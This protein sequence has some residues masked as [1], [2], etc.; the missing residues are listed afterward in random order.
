MMKGLNQVK[1]QGT[2]LRV[3]HLKLPRAAANQEIELE[4]TEREIRRDKLRNIDAREAASG[5]TE[6]RKFERLEREINT[7]AFDNA[8]CER[9]RSDLE[10]L[11]AYET[12]LELEEQGHS[13]QRRSM[14]A[15]T[16]LRQE[17]RS[18]EEDCQWFSC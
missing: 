16:Y 6:R 15:R 18:A 9:I 3:N 17:A 13:E 12:E 5:Q 14:F 8:T 1:I 2:R 11:G 4:K 10:H 7:L